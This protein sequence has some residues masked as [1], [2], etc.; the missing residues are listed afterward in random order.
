MNT[1]TQDHPLGIFAGKSNADYHGGPG[2]SKSTLDLVRRSLAHFKH[3]QDS[4]DEREETAAMLLGSA[5][6]CAALEP[7]EFEK[8]YALPFDA[9]EW[10]DALATTDEIKARLKDHGLKI[11][12]R[13]DELIER[14]RE[15]D[16]GVQILDD[17]KA[18]HAEEADGKTILTPAQWRDVVGMRD[19]VREHPRIRKLLTNPRGKAELSAYWIDEETGLLCRCRPDWWVGDVVFDLKTTDDAREHSF[20][21]SIEKFRYYVQAPFYLDGLRKAIEQGDE[22]LPEGLEVPRHFVF[23]A[24]EKKAP[25]LTAVYVLEPESM[26]IGRR[27]IREDLSALADAIGRDDW[28]GYSRDIKPIGLP[29]WRLRQEEMEDEQGVFVQ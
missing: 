29:A 7:D 26:E 4:T 1:G 17:L 27:E 6:H 16:P 14:L 8:E 3:A 9:S 12:G 25:Y 19:A 28:P 13:K 24:I 18:M 15:A 22:P 20:E 23:G 10:P 2:K 5:T 11:S 21:R